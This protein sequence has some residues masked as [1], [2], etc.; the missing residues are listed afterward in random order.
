[1]LARAALL[2]LVLAGAA[3]CSSPGIT[4]HGTSAPPPEP[5]RPAGAKPAATTRPA[6]RGTGTTSAS[7]APTFGPAPSP[8]PLPPPPPPPP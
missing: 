5:R 7:A 1:M 6:P 2:G 4:T 3:A 8:N